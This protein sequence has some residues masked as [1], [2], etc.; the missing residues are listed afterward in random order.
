MAGLTPAE[1][2]IRL[3]RISNFVVLTVVIACLFS[4]TLNNDIIENLDGDT[5]AVPQEQ[6][7]K[8]ALILAYF[9]VIIGIYYIYAAYKDYQLERTKRTKIFLYV[10]IILF[11]AACLHLYNFYATPDPGEE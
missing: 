5:E 1:D 2:R 7:R 8:K 10:A 4:M 9:F 11:I 6:I 3:L